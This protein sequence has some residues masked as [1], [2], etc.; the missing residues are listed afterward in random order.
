MDKHFDVIIGRGAGG[1][2]TPA[3]HVAP[4]G[5]LEA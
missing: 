4:A 3:S 2:G 5:S 1:G